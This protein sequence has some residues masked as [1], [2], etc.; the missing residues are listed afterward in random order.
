ME[1]DSRPPLS[2]EMEVGGSLTELKSENLGQ[3]DA[4]YN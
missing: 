3:K 1:V 2:L 4:S